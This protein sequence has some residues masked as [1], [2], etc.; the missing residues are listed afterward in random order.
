MTGMRDRLEMVHRDADYQVVFRS[1]IWR[2]LFGIKGHLIKDF[3][4]EF[5]SAIHYRETNLELD[6]MD[7]LVF[8]MGGEPR[9]MSI[10]Q[11]I[12]ALGYIQRRRLVLLG[13]QHTGQRV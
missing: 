8:R 11:F 3:M 4:L 7:T 9:Q 1:H 2:R 12:L 6:I 10:R 13:L 5:F